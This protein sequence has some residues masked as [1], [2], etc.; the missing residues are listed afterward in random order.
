MARMII[1]GIPHPPQGETWCAVCLSLAKG[2]A[3]ADPLVQERIQDGLAD[4]SREKFV[5]AV[6][7]KDFLRGVELAISWGG[8]PLIMKGALV[9]PLCA[10]HFPAIDPTA[11]PPPPQGPAGPGLY[12]GG[13]MN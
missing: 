6:S 8:H 4:E 10:L 13:S 9:V 1:T 3:F 11:A 7:S 2:E 12:R 5:I